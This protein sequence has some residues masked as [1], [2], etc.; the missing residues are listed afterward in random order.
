MLDQAAF[1][2]D[3]QRLGESLRDT[4]A[5]AF[6]DFLR[7]WKSAVPR[8]PV[9]V[10]RPTSSTFSWV[11]KPV[12]P[13]FWTTL[14]KPDLEEFRAVKSL[15]KKAR[16][17][18]R[19]VRADPESP[20][21]LTLLHMAYDAHRD[22][23]F[24]ATKLVEFLID[25]GVDASYYAGRPSVIADM[26]MHGDVDLLEKLYLRGQDFEVRVQPHM[27]SRPSFRGS[28]LLHRVGPALMVQASTHE[29]KTGETDGRY[30]TCLRRLYQWVPD[31]DA[32]D[33]EGLTPLHR[34]EGLRPGNLSPGLL[35]ELQQGAAYR[36]SQAL[37][38]GLGLD[39]ENPEHQAWVQGS[40]SWLM[41]GKEKGFRWPATVSS[42]EPQAFVEVPGQGSGFPRAYRPAEAGD[43]QRVLLRVLAPVSVAAGSVPAGP[44][45]LVMAQ[46]AEAD[47]VVEDLGSPE[48]VWWVLRPQQVKR[49]FAFE[50][51]PTPRLRSGPRF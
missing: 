2:H 43:S 9:L 44:E 30:H 11:E 31:C 27:P 41:T 18:G 47:G 35:R 51:V 40:L 19:N 21:V 15:L 42:V 39:P 14:G 49:Y 12:A 36:R 13:A 29:R 17:S 8:A 45:A 20:S 3:L 38:M 33:A 23:V 1:E 46:N 48:A 34:I 4:R 28:T 32:V 50:H 10:C 22:S 24:E 25:A 26:A 16:A 37:S 6:S 7:K 5:K